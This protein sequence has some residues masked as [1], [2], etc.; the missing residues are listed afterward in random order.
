MN[1]II[2]AS[3]IVFAKMVQTAP[4]SLGGI[5]TWER[6][7]GAGKGALSALPAVSGVLLTA[8]LGLY[9]I[10]FG[11]DIKSKEKEQSEF[12]R[13]IAFAAE[14]LMMAFTAPLTLAM[15]AVYDNSERLGRFLILVPILIL[16]YFLATHLASFN[17][18]A[19]KERIKHLKTRRRAISKI[20]RDRYS[21]L[22]C[23]W[24]CVMLINWVSIATHAS[25][26]AFP[27]STHSSFPINSFVTFAVCL[28]LVFAISFVGFFQEYS[29]E[30]MATVIKWCIITTAYLALIGL[31]GE[32][33]IMGEVQRS[34]GIALCSAWVLFS[35]LV[36]RRIPESILQWTIRGATLQSA[37]LSRVK[38]IRRLT[39]EIEN[40]K[41]RITEE[42][43]QA[44]DR[45]GVFDSIK[46]R[47]T[48]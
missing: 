41:E 35:S 34:I 32:L 31:F 21:S 15:F 47:F 27:F 43:K 22:K 33:I 45:P 6:M 4:E 11:S 19:D 7:R 14:V 29:Q 30:R 40:L 10:A 38:E 42:E 36:S 48:R 28:W 24:W 26:I 23:S 13:N 5:F 46:Q 3:T 2:I 9:A 18:L 17:V 44:Y 12:R 1:I 25:I 39:K 37:K 16:T 8:I 20:V